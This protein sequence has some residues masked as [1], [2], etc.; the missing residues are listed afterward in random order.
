MS[1]SQPIGPESIVTLQEITAETVRTICKLSDTLSEAHKR[2]VAPNAVSIAEAHFNEHAW[3]RAIYADE[4][5]VGFIML[6]IGP[7]D[8]TGEPIHFLWRFMIAGPYQKM[9]FGRRA[10]EQKIAELRQQEVPELLVSCGEGEGS[11][12][13][14]YLRLG[15]IPTG[16][17]YGDEKVLNLKL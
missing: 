8:K 13:G 4:T 2:M 17:Y 1:D 5:P 10:L 6:Y 7:D 14:F 12:E 11:P 15:F 9:G 3:F 16:E